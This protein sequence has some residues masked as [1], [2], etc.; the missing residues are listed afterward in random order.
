MEGK[1][2]AKKRGDPFGS[3]AWHILTEIANSVDT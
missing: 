1:G 2:L 3:N